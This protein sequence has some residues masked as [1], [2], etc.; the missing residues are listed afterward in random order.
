MQSLW[1]ALRSE[2]SEDL[3]RAVL[4]AATLNLSGE[5]NVS[6]W[7]CVCIAGNPG[8]TH[9]TAITN[10]TSETKGRRMTDVH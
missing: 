3:G 7:L 10:A 6:F 5:P 4:E 8:P 2:C 9:S 1:A